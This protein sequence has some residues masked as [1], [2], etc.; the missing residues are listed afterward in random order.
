MKK[1]ELKE[2]FRE[3]VQ[4]LVTEEMYK[5]LPKIIKETLSKSLSGSN[6]V[7]T[8]PKGAPVISNIS[9][10]TVNKTALSETLNAMRNDPNIQKNQQLNEGK[11]AFSDPYGNGA[12]SSLPDHLSKAF[13]RNYSE[14]LKKAQEKTR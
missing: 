12:A 10:I 5:V 6:A 13:T 8:A 7:N 9:G 11:M 2:L 3:V 1:S 14:V 4:E